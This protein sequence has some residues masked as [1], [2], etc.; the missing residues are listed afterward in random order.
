MCWAP[1]RCTKLLLPHTNLCGQRFFFWH[2]CQK[3]GGRGEAAEPR[4]PKEAEG[5]LCS[6]VTVQGSESTTLLDMLAIFSHL[7]CYHS[8]AEQWLQCLRGSAWPGSSPAPPLQPGGS[9]V[10]VLFPPKAAGSRVNPKE[11]RRLI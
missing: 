11:N 10:W 8:S 4:R 6:P 5:G 2:C 7:C 3:E 1:V 9:Q